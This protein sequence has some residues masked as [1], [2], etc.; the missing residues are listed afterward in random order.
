MSLRA[1]A[2][3]T[4]AVE[5]IAESAGCVVTFQGG[6]GYRGAYLRNADISIIYVSE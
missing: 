3:Q 5:A 1:M 4:M 2:V 6:M